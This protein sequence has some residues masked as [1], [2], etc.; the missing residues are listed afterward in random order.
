M[1][2]S[3]SFERIL[4]R[5]HLIAFC[6]I[7]ASLLLVATQP[8]VAQTVARS[9]SPSP[10]SADQA[11]MVIMAPKGPVFV[12][13]QISVAKL[14]YREWVGRYLAT[15][16]DTD[17]NGRLNASELN[18]L[19][20]S[21][22]QLGKIAGPQDVLKSVGGDAA[23]SDISAKDFASWL[24]QRLPRAFD[25]MAQPQ[26]SDDAV[27]LSALIDQD[28]NGVISDDELSSILRTLR[29]R[30][31][32]N[33]ETFSVSELMPYR[34]PRS[35][36][37]AVTPD[38]ANLPFFHVTDD[39]STQRAA[40]RILQRYGDGVRVPGVCLRQ[41]ELPADRSLDADELA[42]ILQHP[43]FHMSV[44]VRLS[45]R[46]NTSDID[47]QVSSTAAEFCIITDDSF[48]QTTLRIDGL[49]IQVVARG[50]GANNRAVS[51]G[52]LGQTFSMIDVDRN[53]YLDE[54]E[55]A[56]IVTAM[57]QSGSEGT[58]AEVD[59]NGDKMVVRDELFA[60]TERDFMAAA[61]RI[62]VTVKQDGKTMFGLMD[63]NQD[64]R[65]SARELNNAKL[66]LQKYDL[67]SDGNFAEIELGTQYVLTLGLGRAEIRRAA[68]MLMGNMNAGRGDAI[69]PGT[70]ALSGPEWF[71]RMDRN[72]DGDVSAREFLG[73]AEHFDLL[74]KDRDQLISVTEAEAI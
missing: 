71:R 5:N 47:V 15:Q 58:F 12:D 52:F 56:G 59:Q 66:A 51:R 26:S 61:S 41:P 36:N 50:G 11:T 25:L 40:D 62:E 46:A 17:R 43:T 1:S 3:R 33:D 2:A 68:P 37:V 31:L 39:A 53:Q 28:Q 72:Q 30:D 49:Q 57:R 65:L 16:L 23:A 45:D 10:V 9:P 4:P 55:F 64:R 70:T 8:T 63:V 54:S 73:T 21:V 35:Q 67:N 32:D 42:A 27:R 18:L 74:D 69:L 34:D 7:V 29:F 22:R 19:T 38:V 24:R 44:L 20:D 6:A 14:P 60:F 13:L 48:G